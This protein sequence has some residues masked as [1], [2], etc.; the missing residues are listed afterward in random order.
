MTKQNENP[1]ELTLQWNLSNV[2]THSSDFL[3][4]Y[5]PWIVIT[6]CSFFLF[7]KYV[8]QVSP[9]VMT[10]PLMAEFH[11]SGV[12]LGNLAATYF[13]AYLVTQLFVGPLLDRY[14][15]RLL[16]AIAILICAFGT[17]AFANTHSLLSAQLARA[18]I[19]A[20]TAFATVS[21]M[22]MSAIWFRPHQVAFVDGLLA[23]A[24][25]VGALCGQVPLTLMVTH[26]GWRES[27][28]YFGMF[29]VVFAFIFLFLA[30]DKNPH[31]IRITPNETSRINFAAISALCKDKKNWLLTFYSGLA[32]TPIAVLGGLWGNPFF[33]VAHHLT[34]TEA[35]SYTSLIFLGLAFGG[36]LCGYIAGKTGKSL[37]VMIAGTLIG[38]VAL[39]IAIYIVTIPLWLFGLL[40]FIFGLTTGVF[41]LSF[42]LGKALN[43]IPLAATVVSLI[44]TGDALFG[45]FTEPLIGKFLDVL[46]DGTIVNN[47]HYFSLHN[48]HLALSI[49]PIYLFLALGC[50]CILRS[51]SMTK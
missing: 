36:P 17:L 46:W 15:P 18:L 39:A 22:K 14:S 37:E 28:T 32:F 44:N 6:L 26:S 12:A 11:I 47:A 30:R 24:A 33:E 35:A 9:S 27:L 41:M 34:S 50:L 4:K 49:L 43:P 21:Y 38:F 42:P 7:Y 25:M 51:L 20:G 45:S 13:Y 16:T 40:L 2:K 1:A 29:G 48:Y 31:Q 10:A 8:L 5:Y 19:G 23:T 3:Y